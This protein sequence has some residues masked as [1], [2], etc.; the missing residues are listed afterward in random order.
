MKSFAFV[1]LSLALY[2]AP[3]LAQ[4]PVDALV[5]FGAGTTGGGDASPVTVSSCDDLEAA[6]DTEGAAVVHIDGQLSDCGVIDVQSDKT[7]LGVG[8][9]RYVILA[10]YLI[11]YL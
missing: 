11:K 8:S 1:A 5:G 10:D 9:G 7:I 6:V 3:A 2:G 4:A